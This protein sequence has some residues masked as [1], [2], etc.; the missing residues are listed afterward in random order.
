MVPY[1]NLEFRP[2]S[3]DESEPMQ[4]WEELSKGFWEDPPENLRVGDV[5]WDGESLDLGKRGLWT[6]SG[7]PDGDGIRLRGCKPKGSS[8]SPDTV[9][10]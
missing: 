9:E 4:G 1:H 10:E 3:V 6:E 2:D 8:V 5:C 7:F